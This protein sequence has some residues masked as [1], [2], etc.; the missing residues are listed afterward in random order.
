MLNITKETQDDKSTQ[1]KGV[2]VG[3]SQKASSRIV[4]GT[5]LTD[6]IMFHLSQIYWPDHRAITTSL[7]EQLRRPFGSQAKG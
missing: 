4:I 5:I 2:G 6:R 3:D 1:L 7:R